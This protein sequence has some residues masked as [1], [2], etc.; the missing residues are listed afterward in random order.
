MATCTAVRLRRA[1]QESIGEVVFNTSITGYQE[2]ISDPSYSARSWSTATQIGNVV[3]S[4]DVEARH[5]ACAGFAIRSCRRSG[6]LARRGGAAGLARIER[7]AGHRRH[8]HAGADPL[9]A[10]PGRDARRD[11]TARRRVAA[12]LSSGC[13]RRPR[14]T[15]SIWCRA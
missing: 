6:E 13:A 2:I 9:P 14:W 4:L 3:N 12:V 10:R 11:H 5:V 7:R 1:R 8:R 15:G